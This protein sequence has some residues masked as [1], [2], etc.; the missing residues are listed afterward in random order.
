MKFKLCE[1]QCMRQVSHI[2]VTK[3]SPCGHGV[4]ICFSVYCGEDIDFGGSVDG[5]ILQNQLWVD[6]MA[7]GAKDQVCFLW[8]LQAEL[9]ES[10]LVKLCILRGVS[11]AAVSFAK[12]GQGVSQAETQL[13]AAEPASM[14][15]ALHKENGV[16]LIKAS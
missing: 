1:T 4:V 12:R 6:T 16:L 14:L 11:F 9:A 10:V 3:E 15:S 7:D 5:E 8:S 13:C 2:D